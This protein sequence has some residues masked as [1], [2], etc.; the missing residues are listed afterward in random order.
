VIKDAKY[1]QSL[2]EESKSKNRY[3]YLNYSELEKILNYL[4]KNRP[5]RKRKYTPSIFLNY[6]KILLFQKWQ[7]EGKID[8]GIRC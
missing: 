2:I 3:H 1:F 4:I 7:R 5:K 6:M 8:I